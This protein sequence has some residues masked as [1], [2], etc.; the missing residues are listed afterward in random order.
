MEK[1]QTTA[2]EMDLRISKKLYVQLE[3]R[4]NTRKILAVKKDAL[5]LEKVVKRKWEQN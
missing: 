5:T 4:I 1:E 3:E 2:T